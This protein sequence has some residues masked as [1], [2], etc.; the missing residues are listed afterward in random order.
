MD[1]E[2]NSTNLTAICFQFVPLLIPH[3]QVELHFVLEMRH[4]RLFGGKSVLKRKR[5]AGELACGIVLT[6]LG[7]RYAS[8]ALRAEHAQGPFNLKRW[9]VSL[10]VRRRDLAR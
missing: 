7:S 8:D 5:D 6:L 4:T 2:Q 9:A 1:S 10:L 3:R